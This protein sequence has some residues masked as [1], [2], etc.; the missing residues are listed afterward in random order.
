MNK[1]ISMLIKLIIFGGL[2]GLGILYVIN[3]SPV[4]SMSSYEKQEMVRPNK[5]G[6]SSSMMSQFFGTDDNRRNA[7]DNDDV[8]L[9]GSSKRYDEV[10][11][12]K[13]HHSSDDK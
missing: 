13:S 5:G 12:G 7:A 3:Q 9:M 6:S 1:S 10:R 8:S 11:I 4:E 2:T